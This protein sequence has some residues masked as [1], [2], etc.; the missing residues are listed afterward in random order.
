MYVKILKTADTIK[1]LTSTA[2]T[3]SDHWIWTKVEGLKISSQFLKP[4]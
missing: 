3:T 2:I 1:D 4:S